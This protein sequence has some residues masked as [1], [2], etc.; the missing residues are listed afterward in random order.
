MIWFAVGFG[1][2][3][4]AIAR[5][6]LSK[7]NSEYPYGTLIANILGCALIGFFYFLFQQKEGIPSHIKVFVVS[8][9]LGSL[10][11]FS[12]F[13][14]ELVL[15]FQNGNYVKFMLYLFQSIVLGL[16]GVMIGKKIC[17]LCL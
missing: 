3:V 10:T 4:G 15:F 14:L 13:S 9:I 16:V 1:G 12:T 7:F 8:G 5:F 17:E 2:A 6:A 11:T